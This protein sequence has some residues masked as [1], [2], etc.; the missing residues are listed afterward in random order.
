MSKLTFY[1]IPYNK[2]NTS[3]ISIT[4]AYFRTE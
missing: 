4:G 2:Y 1:H 3:T